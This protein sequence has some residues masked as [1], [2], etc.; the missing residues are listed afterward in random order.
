MDFIKKMFAS[1]FFL[2]F[3]PG[4]PATYSSFF[5]LLFPFF[6]RNPYLY[7]FFFISYFFLSFLTINQLE[8]IWGKDD[9][10]ITADEVLGILTTFFFIPI[11]FKILIL[12]FLLF[13]FYDIL[14][15]SFLR[16]VER[17]TGA[18]GV[19]L[20]DILAGILANITL[21]I[22]LMLWQ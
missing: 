9:R 10:K 14:K 19:I 5:A 18:F 12:G 4:A 15:L 1:T 20:D 17:I 2:G 3:L 22:I 21:R 13:R 11:N 6:I 16:K 8:K 7:I